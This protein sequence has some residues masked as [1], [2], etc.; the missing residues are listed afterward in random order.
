MLSRNGPLA[1]STIFSPEALMRAW[2]SVRRKGAT[3][4]VDGITVNQF[5]KNLKHHLYSL[6]KDI[7]SGEYQPSPVR[8]VR[9]PKSNGG[10][11]PLA[12]WTLRDRV[13]QRVVHDTVTPILEPIFLECNYGF[14]PGR[15]IR[16]AIAAV[17][18]AREDG[19]LWVVDA[20]IQNFFETM[21]VKVLLVLVRQYIAEEVIRTLIALWL[22]TPVANPSAQSCR[23][24]AASQGGVITPLLANLYLHPLDVHLAY[25]ARQCVVV[26]YADDLVVLCQRHH[27][28]ER[29]L[30]V[31]KTKLKQIRLT[32]NPLKTRIVHLE[33]GFTFLGMKVV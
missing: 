12:I 25:R 19:L 7:V 23:L 21:D 5:E 20:D 2:R 9:I 27:Q 15:S 11:R 31:I 14:R 22:A 29:A 30:R 3:P 18:K 24:A 1:T 33:E 8:T 28:A 16:D 26:R 32:L 6:R 10:W 13:A 4:G 17:Q